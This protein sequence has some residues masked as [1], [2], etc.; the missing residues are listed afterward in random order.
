MRNVFYH[1][2]LCSIYYESYDSVLQTVSIK[3]ENKY[4]WPWEGVKKTFSDPPP[5]QPLMGTKKI[6][7]YRLILYLYQSNQNAMKWTILMK[8]IG[9]DRPP[10]HLYSK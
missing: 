6:D 8:I 1:F 2:P 7:F 5:P 10:R 4:G 9:F 3:A